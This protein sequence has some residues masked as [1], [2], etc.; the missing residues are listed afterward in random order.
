VTT[1][2]VYR[3]LDL[4]FE[5]DATDPGL[6]AVLHEVFDALAS[7]GRPE[8]S[9]TI[10][11]VVDGSFI[12]RVDGVDVLATE[13]S[14]LAFAHL[15]WEINRRAIDRS[16]AHRL[17]LHASAVQIDDRAA[18]FSGPSGAG[19]S[20]IAAGLVAA[21]FDYLT[22]DVVVI[23]P[24]DAQ[25]EPYPKPVGLG[26]AVARDFPSLS[27]C[28]D[29]WRAFMGDEWYVTP[30][31]LGGATARGA[32]P[33]LV[34]FPRYSPSGDNQPMPVSRADALV[35]MAEHSFN[36]IE[37]AP[38]SFELLARVLR[39]CECYRIEFSSLDRVVDLVRNSLG[40]A[41]RPVRSS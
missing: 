1:A 31:M 3:S 15:L 10:A 34:V 19:K 13:I 11:T 24:I 23:E 22:D 37:H 2:R 35:Q 8:L 28:P 32:V 4:V 29:Q 14:S 38:A 7:T 17:L 9:C 41:S 27:Q 25:I 5:L 33:G 18:M 16:H 40:F 30:G 6:R 12:V 20:T 36:F 21:G 26:Q 39:Q